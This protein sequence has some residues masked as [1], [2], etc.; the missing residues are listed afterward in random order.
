MDDTEDLGSAESGQRQAFP[1]M[2]AAKRLFASPMSGDEASTRRAPRPN[3]LPSDTLPK[4]RQRRLLLG[5]Q[6]LQRGMS[7][8][9]RQVRVNRTDLALYVRD[10]L[11]LRRRQQSCEVCRDGREFA[12]DRGAVRCIEQLSF[13]SMDGAQG[14]AWCCL[15][16]FR[17]L[18]VFEGSLARLFQGSRYWSRSQPLP[19]SRSF[20]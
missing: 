6:S 3:L 4:L 9:R 8:L 17:S 20:Q 2:A 13:G 18:A 5:T 7:L 10:D 12:G 1:G 11:L 16:S 14:G 15:G 19:R